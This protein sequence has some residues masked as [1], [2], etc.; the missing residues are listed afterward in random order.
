[1]KKHPCC[2]IE[3]ARL[4]ERIKSQNEALVIALTAQD[5]M[6]EGS[7]RAA[8]EAMRIAREETARRLDHLNNAAERAD[9]MAAKTVTRELFDTLVDRV[10]ALEGNTRELTGKLWLPMIVAAGVA[11]AF[12]SGLAYLVLK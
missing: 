2:A 10:L 9:T 8:M 1:M 5:R 6:R 12:A 7:E 3:L 11:A 4:D